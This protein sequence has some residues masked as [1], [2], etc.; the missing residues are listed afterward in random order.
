MKKYKLTNGPTSIDFQS[1]E[2][3][4]QFKSVNPEWANIEAIS[5]E[6]EPQPEP[7]FVPQE[8]TMWQLRAAITLAGLKDAVEAALNELPEPNKIVGNIAWEYANNILRQSPTVLMLQQA[9]SLTDEQADQ[10][11]IT[12]Y[13][14]NA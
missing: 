10:L 4:A 6:E 3:V 2:A 9:L 14:I 7:V 12:G 1:L 5:Y 8:I 11:F 13:S